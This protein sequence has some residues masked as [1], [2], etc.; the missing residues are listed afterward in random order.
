MVVHRHYKPRLPVL[1]GTEEMRDEVVSI[2]LIDR[3]SDNSAAS[4]RE[5]ELPPRPSC[6]RLPKAG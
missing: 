6:A 2:R 5:H 4:V 1:E 3:T